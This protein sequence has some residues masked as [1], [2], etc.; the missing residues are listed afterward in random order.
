MSL[1]IKTLNLFQ[2]KGSCILATIAP[3]TLRWQGAIRQYL[4]R[5]QVSYQPN[6]LWWQNESIII[7]CRFSSWSHPSVISL[8]TVKSTPMES[9]HRPRHPLVVQVIKIHFHIMRQRQ[10]GEGRT[11]LG[12]ET[13][14]RTHTHI[15]KVQK[16]LMRSGY[17]VLISDTVIPAASTCSH[18]SVWTLK[19]RP[20]SHHIHKQETSC[21]ALIPSP[22]FSAAPIINN[23]KPSIV[24]IPAIHNI[25]GIQMAKW[26]A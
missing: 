11:D 15:R 12:T 21:S 19:L 16:L 1:S 4:C 24:F 25:L 10:S 9:R 22:L 14:A 3:W 17:A 6:G 7:Q 23:K 20:D 5:N 26:F 2:L 13:H 18:C 8:F